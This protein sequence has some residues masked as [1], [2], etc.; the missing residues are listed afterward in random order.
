M[1][2]LL[3]F[4]MVLIGSCVKQ[5][6]P[7]DLETKAKELA[8]KFIIIDGHID[9][10]YK[11]VE[12]WKDISKFDSTMNYDYV[13][14]SQGGLDAP[15]FSIYVAASYQEKGEGSNSENHTG[16]AYNRALQLIEVSN[17]VAAE[18]PD[19]F[20]FVDHP[21]QIRENH[22]KGL[23]SYM[24]GMENGA[25]IEGDLEKLRDL[26]SKGIRY[27]TV[28]HGKWNHLGDASYDDTKHWNGLSPFGREVVTEMNKLGVLVDISHVSDSTF[29][30]VM[31]VTKVPAIASH[32]S[33]RHFTPGWERNMDDNMIKK[34]AENGGVIM[35]NY[36]SSFVTEKANT[37]R[38]RMMDSALVVMKERGLNT[39]DDSKQREIR[40][41]LIEKVGY[42]FATTEEVVD[43]IDHVK[44]LVGIDYVG[45][46]SDYDGVGDSLPIGLK[47]VSS[48]PNL[49]HEMLKRGYSEEEIEKVCGTNLLRVWDKVAA[50]ADAN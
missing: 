23:K 7:A 42:P 34:L 39:G 27:V 18:N 35:I 28:T 49:I 41:E 48:Y 9:V 12:E 21:D 10:P 29:Y 30:D 38:Q 4:V 33:C 11:I 6:E 32:S 25:P 3:V 45:L 15:F 17:R 26:A 8:Q 37:F 13:K 16:G 5:G 50:F 19:K 24:Y 31:E 14:A 47:D 22:K 36:G 1:R 46:G 40:E 44:R 2:V 43:H 20:A